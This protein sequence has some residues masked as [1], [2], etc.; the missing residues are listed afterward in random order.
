MN[1]V[2]A[3]RWSPIWMWQRLLRAGA[4]A[5]VTDV[6]I[7]VADH[8]EPSYIVE[9]KGRFAAVEEQLRRVEEW[10]ALYPAVMEPWRDSTGRPF[11]HTYFYPAEQFEPSVIDCLVQ[12]CRQGWG[13]IEVHLHHGLQQPDTSGNTRR[14]LVTFRD[15]L[16]SRGALSRWKTERRP[17]FAFVHGNWALANSAD[18]RW[19][20]VDDEMQILADTGC[21][22]DFTMPCAPA[23][24]Q[25]LKINSIYECG[26]PLHVRAPHRKGYDLERGREPKTFPIIVQGPL[27]LHRRTRRSGRL[28]IENGAITDSNPPT[29]ARYR[30]W[31]DAGVCV[32][33][34]PEWRFVKLHCHG[35]DPRDRES[36]LGTFRTQFLRDLT[37]QVRSSTRLHFVT[38]REMVNIILAACDGKE[39][40]PADYRDYRLVQFGALGVATHM[41]AE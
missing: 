12:H 14:T 2:R 33:G 27:G 38:A 17:R 6:I 22:A 39:G 28:Y 40:N 19:C 18:N 34:R 20:G 7:S 9:P 3:L 26:L 15:A 35:M 13:E 25:V 32:R 11:V 16:A 5:H 24:P 30:R 41:T 10:C 36:M 8:F 37:Q 23:V 1:G 31:C 21:Y 29:L 4:A